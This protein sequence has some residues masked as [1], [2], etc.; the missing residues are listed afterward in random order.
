MADADERIEAHA[1]PSIAIAGVTPA[2]L[3][4]DPLAEAVGE[5]EPEF[6]R[7]I[8]DVP[9]MLA[10]ATLAASAFL[11]WYKLPN[12][13]KASG[14]ATGGWGPLIFLLGVAAVV[15][16][17]LRRFR[18]H[19]TLPYPESIVLE[20]MGWL[21]TITAIL[22]ARFRPSVGAIQMQTVPWVY[23]AVAAGIVLALLAGRVSGKT[24]FVSLPGWYR[25]RAGKIGAALLLVV[26]G[27]GAAFGFTNSFKVGPSSTAAGPGSGKSI[28]NPKVVNGLPACAKD[29]P[30]PTDFTPFNG[31]ESQNALKTCV[32]TFKTSRTAADAAAQLAQAFTRGGWTFK[33]ET[34]GAASSF[35]ITKP[36]CGSATVIASTGKDVYAVLNVSNCPPK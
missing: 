32:A 17:A 16:I 15:A 14:W 20:G 13:V 6:T 5:P 28:G 2:S 27:G 31:I 34:T 24:P 26:I 3:G 25:R 33:R 36:R 4:P 18:V 7:R 35:T 11:P 23:A 21:A 9:M 10:A 19:V 30:V 12:G 22:K 8:E 1:E 29:F